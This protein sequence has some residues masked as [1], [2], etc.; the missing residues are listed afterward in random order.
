MLNFICSAKNGARVLSTTYNLIYGCSVKN[1]GLKKEVITRVAFYRSISSSLDPFGSQSFSPKTEENQLSTTRTHVN[2]VDPSKTDPFSVIQDAFSS[3]TH[4]S[5]KHLKLY[6]NG[7]ENNNKGVVKQSSFQ[8][9][10]NMETD[11]I[12]LTQGSSTTRPSYETN[13]HSESFQNSYPNESK[14]QNNFEQQNL[15]LQPSA[16]AQK[17]KM[18]KNQKLVDA[19][20]EHGENWEYI[21]KEIYKGEVGPEKLEHDWDKLK[22]FGNFT[23]QQN[24]VYP[25]WTTK[26][27]LKLIDAVKACGEDWQKISIEW[28][29]SKRSQVSL[30]KKW[31]KIVETKNNP[32]VNFNRLKQADNQFRIN[33]ETVSRNNISPNPERTKLNNSDQGVRQSQLA[34]ELGR[35][36]NLQWSNIVNLFGQQ[37]ISL[38]IYF[39]S[40]LDCSWTKEENSTLF[41]AIKKYGTDDWEKI[42]K[43]LPGKSLKNIKERCSYILWE[44]QEVETFDK[45]LEQYGTNWSKISEVV[46]SRS[47]GQ[48]W[49]YWKITTGYDLSKPNSENGVKPETGGIQHANV[50]IQFPNKELLQMSFER[51]NTEEDFIPEKTVD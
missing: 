32:H 31:E 33:R 11:Y 48:C 6:D 45:A 26:E 40:L 46:G 37:A 12:D 41:A 51:R 50:F 3:D 44:Q 7:W 29:D 8:R 27:M 49:S 24:K 22:S 47:P 23:M 30:E 13:R 16:G 28:F 1:I 10:K 4:E 14:L 42:L 17:F 43:L 20:D 39:N 15:Q 35:E 5:S 36:L 2:G 9:S 34:H 21:S 18:S 38:E 25:F 19:I